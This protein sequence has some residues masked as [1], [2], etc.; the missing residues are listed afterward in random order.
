MKKLFFVFLAL[1]YICFASE[2][3]DVD[4]VFKT[5]SN[6]HFKSSTLRIRG[7]HA[8]FNNVNFIGTIVRNSE[9]AYSNFIGSKFFKATITNSNFYHSPS[10]FRM[11][12]PHAKFENVIFDNCTIENVN[13]SETIFQNVTFINCTFKNVLWN[14]AQIRNVLFQHCYIEDN[15][16]FKKEMEDVDVIHGSVIDTTVPLTIIYE[17]I[18]SNKLKKQVDGFSLLSPIDMEKNFNKKSQPKIVD[19]SFIYHSITYKS[20][21]TQIDT[22]TVTYLNDKKTQTRKKEEKKSAVQVK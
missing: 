12:N 14:N 17:K 10:F 15:S 1:P 21:T 8:H 6:G 2:A 7:W 5:L 9:L 22:I 4:L 11:E 13:F 20:E 3:I 16:S 19:K 18:T